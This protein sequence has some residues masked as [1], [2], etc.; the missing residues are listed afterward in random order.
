MSNKSISLNDIKFDLLKIIEPWDGV[1]EVGNP[2]P[3]RGMFNAYLTDLQKERM[4]YDYSI[5]TTTRDNAYTFDVNVRLSPTR[6]P[7]KLKIHVGVF[8][9]PW[10]GQAA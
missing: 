8:Q 6:S 5:D 3:V 9:A 10:T 7:K 1:L 2:K 4:I